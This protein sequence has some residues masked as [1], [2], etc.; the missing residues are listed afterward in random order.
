M[1]LIAAV[2]SGTGNTKKVVETLSEHLKEKGV[3]T[4]IYGI[5]KDVEIPSV[6]EYDG[7]VIGYP[8]H[9][10]NAPTPVLE[11][12][13]G[14]PEG[15]GKRVWFV[16]TSGEPL[17]LNDASSAQC[18][19]HL[20]RL[21]YEV[22]GELHIVMPY[23]IIF[24]H[25]DAMAARMWQ[26]AQPKIEAEAERI[27][28]GTGTPLPL[29]ALKRGW[30]GF[31]RIEHTAMPYIGRGFHADEKCIG[32]GK[33]ARVCPLANVEMKEGKPAFGKH[34]VGCMGCAFSCPKEA[35]HTGIL[36]SWRVNGSYRY[37]AMPASDKEVCKYCHKSYLNY[38]H[39]AESM[40]K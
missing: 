25:S 36:N 12:V 21:G 39:D 2:F 38:F 35:I 17:K 32:C 20:E 27:A 40:V 3:E 28:R 31:V 4:E 5:R 29:S 30:S 11:Y 23:N 37:D 8:V 1:K 14:L 9:G 22:K 7:L 6:E 13:K 24:R 15:A 33:C 26:A 16:K 10:F 19:K 18:L 34:C